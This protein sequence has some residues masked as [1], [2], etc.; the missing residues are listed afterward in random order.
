MNTAVT[1]H[2]EHVAAPSADPQAA[3]ELALALIDLMRLMAPTDNR[4]KA[5][6][7]KRVKRLLRDSSPSLV[8]YREIL[9]AAL[10]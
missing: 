9:R 1:E 4:G 6:F 10:S 3:A 7:R 5:L 8:F 2:S